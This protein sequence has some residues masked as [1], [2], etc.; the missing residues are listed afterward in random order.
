[1][2]ELVKRNAYFI[3]EAIAVLLSDYLL[4]TSNYDQLIGFIPSF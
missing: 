2:R 4:E 3:Q 1:M